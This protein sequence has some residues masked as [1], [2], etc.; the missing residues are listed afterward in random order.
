MGDEVQGGVRASLGH[1]GGLLRC[2]VSALLA[3]RPQLVRAVGDMRWREGGD[4]PGHEELSLWVDVTA[5]AAGRQGLPVT[6]VA[7]DEA[8]EAAGAVGLGEFDVAERRDRS[9]WVLGM[10]VR[11]A[12][13]GRAWAACC[14]PGW[15]GLPPGR[16]TR[17]CGW[18]PATRLWAFTGGVAGRR[19]SVFRMPGVIR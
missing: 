13:R 19:P 17:G 1:C 18:R 4:E 16:V 15:S 7:V 6:W 10:V 11:P 9:P 3:D 14:C 8:G 2:C 12:S 5:R